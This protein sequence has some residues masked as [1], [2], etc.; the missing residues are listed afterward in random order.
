[1]KC[2]VYLNYSFKEM[3]AILQLHHT[4]AV[5]PIYHVHVPLYMLSPGHMRK[6]CKNQH[7]NTEMPGC[8]AIL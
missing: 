5:V 2:K 4:F 8:E 6:Q 1:M 7:Q 3:M